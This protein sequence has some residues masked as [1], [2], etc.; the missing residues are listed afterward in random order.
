MFQSKFSI[1]YTIGFFL[2]FSFF[3]P[4]SNYLTTWTIM[5]LSGKLECKISDINSALGAII[6]NFCTF[7]KFIVNF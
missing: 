3:R 7:T 2:L 4:N 5:R 6:K 1:D